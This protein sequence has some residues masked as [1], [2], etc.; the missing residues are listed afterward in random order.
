MP[1]TTKGPPPSRRSG[2][3]TSAVREYSVRYTAEGGAELSPL[4]LR[5]AVANA[6]VHEAVAR[7]GRF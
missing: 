4:L 6:F 3:A 7:E 5:R 2:S 1:V